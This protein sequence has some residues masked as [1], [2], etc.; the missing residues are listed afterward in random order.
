M[1]IWTSVVWE[2]GPATLARQSIPLIKFRPPTVP[3]PPGCKAIVSGQR[4]TGALPILLRHQKSFDVPSY[5]HHVE[6]AHRGG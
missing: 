3:T 2:R 5:Q 6:P 4:T 1:L